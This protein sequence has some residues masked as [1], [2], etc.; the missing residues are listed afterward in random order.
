MCLKKIYIDQYSFCQRSQWRLIP[1]G[2]SLKRNRIL[3][4]FKL[5]SHKLQKTKNITVKNLS[6]PKVIKNE[7]TSV[8]S[9][10]LLIVYIL[11]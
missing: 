7:M 10:P 4:Q 8:P 1:S 11:P 9:D 3:T 5:S 6:P 2:Q